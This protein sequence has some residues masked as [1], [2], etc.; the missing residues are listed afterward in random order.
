MLFVK[1]DPSEFCEVPNVGGGK[2][3]QRTGMK[4][5]MSWADFSAHE[6]TMI[7]FEWKNSGTSVSESVHMA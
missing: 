6:K 5:R 3:L 7:E 2:I 1:F 4:T